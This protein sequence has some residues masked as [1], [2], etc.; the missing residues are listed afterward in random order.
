MILYVN[1]IFTLA[2]KGNRIKQRAA[3]SHPENKNKSLK[4]KQ[5]FI[6]FHLMF[7]LRSMLGLKV[8][9]IHVFWVLLS[10]LKQDLGWEENKKR[11]LIFHNLVLPF[12]C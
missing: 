2:Q 11:R 1:K 3:E 10:G 8:G 5:Q 9:Q 4:S 12:F 7:S 6:K